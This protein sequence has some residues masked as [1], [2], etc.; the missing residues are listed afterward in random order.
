MAEENEDIGK[1]V[2]DVGKAAGQIG[3]VMMFLPILLFVTWLFFSV[4]F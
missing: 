3:C 4:L 2:T 1:A